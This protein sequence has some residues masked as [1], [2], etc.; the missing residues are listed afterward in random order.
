MKKVLLLCGGRSAEHEISLISAKGILG[1][2]DRTQFSPVLVG[3]AKDGTWYLEDEKDYYTGE[4]RADRIALNTQRPRV[5]L[6]PYL[7]P[8]RKGRL[9]VTGQTGQAAQ[10]FDVVFPILHGQYGEE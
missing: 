4:F 10:E 3:V 6:A 2:L 5:T 7:S 9:E 8:S 1:A